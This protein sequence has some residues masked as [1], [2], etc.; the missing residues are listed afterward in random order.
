MFRLVQYKFV[1]YMLTRF[2]LSKNCFSSLT[3]WSRVLVETL[4][5]AQRL[6]KLLV[7]YAARKLITILSRL[8]QLIF[9]TDITVHPCTT[10]K[11]DLQFTDTISYMRFEVFAAVKFLI[12]LWVVTTCGLVGI[13]KRFGEKCDR[14]C[15]FKLRR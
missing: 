11:R 8:M 7:L 10:F 4:V 14:H 9:K 5:V 6:E 2:R 1:K 15:Q 3:L 12:V 13:R